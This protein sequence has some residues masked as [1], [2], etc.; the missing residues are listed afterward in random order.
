MTS[1]VLEVKNMLIVSK[2]RNDNEVIR[3]LKEEAE[4]YSLAENEGKRLECYLMLSSL[5][6][7]WLMQTTG[8]PE[9]IQQKVDVFAT[10]QEDLMA[11]SIFVKLPNVESPFPSLDRKPIDRNSDSTVHLVIFGDTDLAEAMAMNAALVAHYPNYCRDHRLKT[12]ITIVSD[13]IFEWR[14][15]LVQRYQHLFDHSYYRTINLEDDNPHCDTHQPHYWMT[16]EDFVDMEWEFVNGNLRN[17]ALRSKLQEWGEAAQQQLTIAFCMDDQQRNFTEVFSLPE[18]LYQKN[19]TILCYTEDAD[20]MEM[21]KQDEKYHSLYPF[22]SDICSQEVLKSLKQLAKRINYVYDYC[23]SLPQEMEI[24]AP[25][26]IDESRLD[27][28]WATVGSLPKQYSNIFNAM[29]IGTKMHS[30]GHEQG[31]WQTYYALSKQEIEVMTEVEHNRWNVEELMLGYRPVTDEEQKEIEA[32]ISLKKKYRSQKVH[33]DLRA[34][35]DLR[36]DATGKQVYV[37]DLAL[38]QGIPLIVKSCL[39]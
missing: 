12:R 34:F 5:T 24:C 2:N 28:L 11:K 37:Y 22:G 14:N 25:M 15:R 19:T 33:Y 20:M 21:V 32:D 26:E 39:L 27:G 18:S 23:F 10:T 4:K 36:P 38:T 1:F 9:D 17:E 16:R 13:D 31:D 3:L 35:N 30:L 7:L 8:I 29:T 6:S